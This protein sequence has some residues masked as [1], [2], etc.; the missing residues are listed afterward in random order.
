MI[1]TVIGPGALG[2]LFAAFLSKAGHAVW[3]LDHNLDRAGVINSQGICVDGYDGS[4]CFPVRSTVDACEIGKTDIVLLCVKSYDV[5]NALG[6]AAPL[7]EGG[8]L[9]VAMQNGLGHYEALRRAG[10]LWAI[11]ITAQGATLLQTGVVGHGGTGLTSLGFLDEVGAVGRRRLD[12]AALML[13]EAGLLCQ[14]SADI[15]A[16]VWGKLLVNVGINALTAIYDCPN[17]VLLEDLHVRGQLS[18]AVCEA[19]AVAVAKG[20][21]I[22]ADPVAEAESVCRATSNNISSML[23]DIRHGRMTEIESINGAIV[24]EAKTLGLAVPMNLKL[25][26]RVRELQGVG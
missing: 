15:E 2:C 23:Q 26:Q 3:L 18:Q 12:E 4:A 1:I 14:V 25:T 13:D 5:A 16:S 21:C 20:I 22:A 11:G 6:R 9:F 19:A 8:P 17:G 7:L 10:C 24:R